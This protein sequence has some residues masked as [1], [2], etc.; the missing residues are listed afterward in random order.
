[1]LTQDTTETYTTTTSWGSQYTI[2][3]SKLVG[4]AEPA[5]H[6][7]YQAWNDTPVFLAEGVPTA[8]M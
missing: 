5:S 1:V 4:V 8:I 6:E 3:Q 2:Y 7:I